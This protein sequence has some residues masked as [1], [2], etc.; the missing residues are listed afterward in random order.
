MIPVPDIIRAPEM[1]SL[2][3]QLITMTSLASSGLGFLSQIVL[4]RNFGTECS[5]NAY[6][7]A[8][9][10]PIFVGGLLSSAVNISLTPRLR[11]IFRDNPDSNPLT[12]TR[13]SSRKLAACVTTAGWCIVPLQYATLPYHSALREAPDLT[14]LMLGCWIF[15]GL[16]VQQSVAAAA[17]VAQDRPLDAAMLPLFSPLISLCMMLI[18]AQTFGIM[19]LLGGQIIGAICSLLVTRIRFASARHD[20][21]TTRIRVRAILAGVSHGSI[22]VACFTA[23][24]FLD[25]FL[26]PRVGISTVAQIAYAQ[27]LVIG[28]GSLTVAA[29]FALL[30][31][32]FADIAGTGSRMAFRS[33]VRSSVT[34]SMIPALALAVVFAA[35]GPAMVNIL[36]GHGRFSSEDAAQVGTAVRLMSPGMVLMLMTTLLYRAGFALPH[37]PKRLL[38]VGVTWIIA[39]TC[40]GI[41]MRPWGLAGLAVAYSCTWIISGAL[42]VYLVFKASSVLPVNAKETH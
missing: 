24:P 2:K 11:S 12:S 27:R 21:H 36:F 32:R 8:L 25:S 20:S 1:R 19:T 40:L 16:L 42:T 28:L 7:F 39:Y 14:V 9:G 33:S 17:L 26:A 6:F 41:L 35:A 4:A 15:A 38:W 5:V 18:G 29:P 10:V 13:T 37:G 3:S 22:A 34:L 23:Y 31:T 30:A